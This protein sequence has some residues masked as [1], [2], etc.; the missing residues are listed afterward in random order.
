MGVLL[1]VQP[2]PPRV[3]Q[4]PPHAAV[5]NSSI[6]SLPMPT[7]NTS[8]PDSIST[9]H[10]IVLPLQ[11]HRPTVVAVHPRLRRSEPPPVLRALH[12]PQRP[13]GG[14]NGKGLD[15]VGGDRAIVQG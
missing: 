13:G 7:L 15:L 8:S 12:P 3:P 4:F 9:L 1:L 6:E 11:Q 10:R 2:N 14:I 5:S